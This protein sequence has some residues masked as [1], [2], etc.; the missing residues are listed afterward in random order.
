MIRR[1][2]LCLCALCFCTLLRAEP[3]LHLAA[4]ARDLGV[5]RAVTSKGSTFIAFDDLVH[6]L[7]GKGVM[8]A[9]TYD[10]TYS[11]HQLRLIH[12]STAAWMNG[13]I[14]ALARA[15][16][17][18]KGHCWV[19]KESAT[20]LATSLLSEENRNLPLVWGA[21]GQMKGT[22]A[23]G[24]ADVQPIG[25]Q[26][27]GTPK[28]PKEAQPVS[29]TIQAHSSPGQTAQLTQIRFG[30]NGDFYRL[31]IDV[32]EQGDAP[33]RSMGDK[34]LV[35]T[36]DTRKIGEVPS[37]NSQASA[38]VAKGQ[39][40]SLTVQTNSALKYFWLKEPRRLVIDWN[41]TGSPLTGTVVAVPG[42]P[43]AQ[44]KGT[45]IKSVPV[46]APAS[47]PTNRGATASSQKNAA[48]GASEK[49]TE[50]ALP[51]ETKP[52]RS[53]KKPFVMIDPG[54]GG[55]DTGAT[56]GSYQEKIIALQIAQKLQKALSAR[57]IDSRLT[58]EGDTYPTLGERPAMANALRAD[59]FVSIHLNSL[60]TKSGTARGQ[61]IYI[62]ALPTDKD[63]ERLAKLENVEI[64]DTGKRE[65][66]P[67][68][69]GMLMSILGNM[70]QNAKI[71]EST[72]LAEDMY[73]EGAG[74]G[75]KMRRVAQ[76]PFAVLRG[77]AMPAVLVETGFI[78][79]SEE[80]KLL[81]SSGY[82][83]KLAEAMA[84]GLQ[85]YLNAIRP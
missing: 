50:S 79:H 18:A 67:G 28:R 59:A 45:D 31:V 84:K 19:E 55:K 77:A 53:G 83:T 22:S 40:G 8:N 52:L 3:G 66:D 2:V 17:L 82:Q 4:G 54:H 30:D 7:G 85:Q 64:T 44:P 72:V 27:T 21:Q 58:R 20:K 38:A 62:M 23:S 43:V 36:G 71:E 34:T 75:V 32:S 70:R 63:A 9:D 16:Q 73:N 46:A 42:A 74:A 61:E 1:I 11:I 49:E 81:A 25:G 6:A 33:I 57:G 56:R 39:N 80:V 47:S 10:V 12:N 41:K 5:I 14:L 76:A 29:T 13:S 78:T 69:T 35:I 48:S 60:A 51:L 68:R 26:Q 37:L 24:D 15:P 65:I